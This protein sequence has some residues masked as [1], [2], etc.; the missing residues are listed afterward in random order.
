MFLNYFFFQEFPTHTILWVKID[1]TKYFYATSSVKML[2]IVLAN[3]CIEQPMS[4]TFK[5]K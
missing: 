1:I 2:L 4:L 5:H 3:L